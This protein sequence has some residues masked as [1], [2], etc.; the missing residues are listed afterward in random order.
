VRVATCPYS[1]GEGLTLRLLVPERDLA[2]ASLGAPDD[3]VREVRGWLATGNGLVVVAGPASSGRTTTIAALLAELDRGAAKV[4]VIDREEE[5]RLPGVGRVRARPEEGFGYEDALRAQLGLDLDAVALAE[6]PSARAV[7]IAA[8]VALSG[9]LVIAGVDARGAP[10]ALV[11]L[12]ETGLDADTA[13]EAVRGVV[14]QRLLRV[15]EGGRRVPVFEV[16][17]V[18]PEMRKALRAGADLAHLRRAAEHQGMTSLRE[19]AQA[20]VDAGEVDAEE[21]ER[22]LG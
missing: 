19:A 17:A 10:E 3:L 8:S 4:S 12:R 16:L 18:T 1:G 5:I 13:A 21:A 9:H 7:R 20:L 6:V 11:A 22:V 15:K 2:L 14:A